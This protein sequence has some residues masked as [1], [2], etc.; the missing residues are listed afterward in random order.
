MSQVLIERIEDAVIRGFSGSNT[1]TQ[2]AIACLRGL[3]SAAEETI[4]AGSPEQ[5]VSAM[6]RLR[7]STRELIE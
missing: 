3:L 2:E 4:G 5:L 7:E 1:D 6:A